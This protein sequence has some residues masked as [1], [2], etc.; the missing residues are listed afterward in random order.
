MALDSCVVYSSVA[1][2]GATAAL[3]KLRGAKLAANRKFVVTAANDFPDFITYQ[4]AAAAGD[5]VSLANFRKSESVRVEA[6][7]GLTDGHYGK[8]D[9]MGRVVDDGASRTVNSACKIIGSYVLGD[10]AQVFALGD[11]GVA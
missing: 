9:A 1:S 7:G 8:F 6:G 11:A 5:V 4:A 10:I 3:A 2:G